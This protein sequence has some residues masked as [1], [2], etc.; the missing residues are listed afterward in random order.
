MFAGIMT[1]PVLC[2]EATVRRISSKQIYLK[3]S[4]YSQETSVVNGLKAC[5]FIKKRITQVFFCEYC[6]IFKNSF[7]LDRI[8]WLL[9]YVL[10]YC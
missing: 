6:E 2:T 9:L 8:W 1:A 4:R 3:I 5:N 10:M 7:F